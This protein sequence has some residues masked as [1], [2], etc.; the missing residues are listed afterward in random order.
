MQYIAKVAST[1][2]ISVNGSSVYT[3]NGTYQSTE[4]GTVEYHYSAANG[5]NI[6]NFHRLKKSGVLLPLTRWNQVEIDGQC[7]QS[8]D[9]WNQNDGSH[10]VRT[11]K[12]PVATSFWL[13]QESDIDSRLANFELDAT[14]YVQAAAAKIYSQGWDALTFSAELSKTILM[15]REFV[16]KHIM[17]A[18]FKNKSTLDRL[19]DLGNSDLEFRY[20]WRVLYYDMKDIIK[21]IQSIDTNRTRYKE[22]VGS[23]F[24]DVT[25]SSYDQEWQSRWNHYSITETLSIG[26]RG[27]VVADIEP[28][29]VQ[30]NAVVTAWELVP[31]S[32]VVDWLLNVGQYLEAMSFLAFSS[33][34]YAAG[35]VYATLRKESTHDSTTWKSPYYGSGITHTG[36]SEVKKTSRI[37]TSVSLTP[38]VK[39]RLDGFKVV[40]LVALALQQLQRRVKW[41]Q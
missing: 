36:W 39:L 32:F 23:N 34:H 30:L 1:G 11:T 21:A 9:V 22:S 28:P 27:T 31:Y 26:L 40:D 6:V 19:T 15:F 38:Q 37:P 10:H 20:G 18:K 29:K 17:T 5:V 25:V 4:T 3:K 35:G 12:R 2:P 14:Y 7:W 41:R 16:R 33:S 13:L 24:D 8:D